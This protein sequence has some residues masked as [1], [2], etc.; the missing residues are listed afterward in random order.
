VRFACPLP[1][2]GR[3][4]ATHTPCG[5]LCASRFLFRIVCAPFDAHKNSAKKSSRRES[6]DDDGTPAFIEMKQKCCFCESEF[7]EA[8]KRIAVSSARG[9]S[10]YTPNCTLLCAPPSFIIKPRGIELQLDLL[11]AVGIS[12][13][14]ISPSVFRANARVIESLRTPTIADENKIQSPCG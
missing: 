11:G 2:V 10:I 13:T 4:R 14:S 5:A 6:H 8:C 9:L 3:H 7:T 1:A 12:H